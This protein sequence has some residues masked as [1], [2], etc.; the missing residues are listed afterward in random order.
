MK[1]SV[2][3]HLSTKLAMAMAAII[4]FAAPIPITA[5]VAGVLTVGAVYLAALDILGRS[6]GPL[7]KQVEQRETEPPPNV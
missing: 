2:D 6:V 1:S 7:A 4:W 3:L 5:T